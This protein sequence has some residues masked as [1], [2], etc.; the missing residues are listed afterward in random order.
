MGKTWI[1]HMSTGARI[2]LWVSILIL[3]GILINLLAI[4]L[5]GDA[6]AWRHWLDKHTTDLLIWRLCLYTLL[7]YGWCSMRTRLL[8]HQPEAARRLCRAE[9][10]GATALAL[11]E[12][13]NALSNAEAT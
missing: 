13:S 5:M 2:A 4:R 10:A 11:L 9:W 8:Q 6:Q 3:T 12:I 1:R 7:I